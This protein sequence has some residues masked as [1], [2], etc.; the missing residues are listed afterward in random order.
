VKRVSV[1]LV[2]AAFVLTGAARATDYEPV[3]LPAAGDVSLPFLCSWG[4][5]WE[6]RS[7]L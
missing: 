3:A 2:A 7:P 6:E 1:L 5:D 4:Y